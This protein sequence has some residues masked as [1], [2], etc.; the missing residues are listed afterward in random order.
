MTTASARPV[1]L[2]CVP[3]TTTE[4]RTSNDETRVPALIGINKHHMHRLVGVLVHQYGWNLGQD[5]NLYS[6][7][8]AE[9]AWG[10]RVA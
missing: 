7:N 1:S 6:P 2:A 3:V 9:T 4:S 8:P 5:G 10:E